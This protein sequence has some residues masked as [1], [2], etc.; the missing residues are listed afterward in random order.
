MGRHVGARTIPGGRPRYLREPRQHGH[1]N[2]PACHHKA[3]L[4]TC[5]EFDALHDAADSRCQMCGKWTSY[6]C[7]DHDHALG[8][9][10][11]RGLLCGVCN[12]GLGYIDRGER[13]ATEAADRYRANAWH[14]TQDTTNKQNRGSQRAW[15]RWCHSSAPVRLDGRFFKHVRSGRIRCA[16]SDRLPSKAAETR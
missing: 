13:P 12:I 3:F 5:A 4:L 7:I 11:V 16:G 6:L 10:A 9:W 15:C 14:L 1:H 2:P 8:K